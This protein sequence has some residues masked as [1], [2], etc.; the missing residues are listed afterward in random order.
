MRLISCLL[1]GVQREQ[2]SLPLRYE[3]HLEFCAPSDCSSL[4]DYLMLHRW[5][6]SRKFNSL[7]SIPIST[8]P[9]LERRQLATAEL[10]NFECPICLRFP[11]LIFPNSPPL[12]SC[13]RLVCNQTCIL[14]VIF[15]SIASALQRSPRTR[16]P[17]RSAKRHRP[18]CLGHNFAQGSCP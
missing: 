3:V 15:Q 2:R 10:V 11:S 7:A 1:F 9:Y 14:F 4:S 18:S 16:S 13:L 8:S 12:H 6:C 5:I 17:A